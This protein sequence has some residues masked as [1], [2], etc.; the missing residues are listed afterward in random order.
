M[1]LGRDR[2]STGIVARPTQ[3]V[4]CRSIIASQHYHDDDADD[5]DDDVEAGDSHERKSDDS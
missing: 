4:H 2:Y 1:D 5:D 3:S